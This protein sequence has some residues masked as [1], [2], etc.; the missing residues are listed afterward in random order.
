MILKLP[1]TAI[2]NGI[3]G[4]NSVLTCAAIGGFFYRLTFVSAGL[5]VAGGMLINEIRLDVKISTLQL[6]LQLQ[7]KRQWWH[8]SKQYAIILRNLYNV[9]LSHSL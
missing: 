5:A 1:L 9:M 3:W 8:F 6:C 4:Y 7:F 2:Y